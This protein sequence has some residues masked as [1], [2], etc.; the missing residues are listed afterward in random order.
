[1]E[2]KTLL[3]S[4]SNI[5]KYD[6]SEVCKKLMDYTF[7]ESEE[8]YQK[9]VSRLGKQDFT[10]ET[11]VDMNK[12]SLIWKL[13]V[14]ISRVNDIIDKKIVSALFKSVDIS[15]NERSKGFISKNFLKYEYDPCIW[16]KQGKSSNTRVI[17][18][19]R[20]TSSNSVIL[21]ISAT[22]VKK[23]TNTRHSKIDLLLV[24]WIYEI[25]RNSIISHVK[26]T[27]KK[28]MSELRLKDIDPYLFSDSIRGGG[29]TRKCLNYKDGQL[30][31]RD[32]YRQPM[33]INMENE[34]D[35]KKYNSLKYPS[36]IVKYRGNCYVGMMDEL[37]NSDVI[38][39]YNRKA[40]AAG[41]I[42][43]IEY[44]NTVILF[45]IHE[46]RYRAPNTPPGLLYPAC[47]LRKERLSRRHIDLMRQAYLNGDI[48]ILGVGK[49]ELIKQLESHEFNNSNDVGYIMQASRKLPINN[50]GHLP[51]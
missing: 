17:C 41:T 45:E 35:M 48:E 14:P 22:V 20:T 37:K 26:Q 42:E 11:G 28:M 50:F 29:Y 19:L 33:V 24:M 16:N 30:N 10:Y 7:I 12:I 40:E 9:F 5:V 8:I 1:M 23:K 27:S 4:T 43:K 18:S 15:S 39:E 34:E 2:K 36:Y 21:T 32:R 46:D 13:Y 49:E 44:F 3:D 47:V 25:W 38:E 31:F 51:R 6:S